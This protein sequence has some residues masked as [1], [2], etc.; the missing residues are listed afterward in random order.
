[1]FLSGG[2]FAPA[3]GLGAPPRD[4]E[5]YLA[6]SAQ[7]LWRGVVLILAATSAILGLL[8][9]WQSVVRPL[10]LAVSAIYLIVLAG[11]TCITMYDFVWGTFVIPIDIR[12]WSEGGNELSSFFASYDLKNTLRASGR[13]LI[14]LASLLTFIIGWRAKVVKWPVALVLSALSLY[15]LQEVLLSMISD[16]SLLNLR[17]GMVPA[18][19]LAPLYFLGLH[20]VFVYKVGKAQIAAPPADAHSAR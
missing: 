20:L 7:E 3:L 10:S 11:A 9:F 18:V 14:Y 2:L 6:N 19:A 13:C 5:V 1:M 15:F 4:A 12:S 17:V 8:S 16:P